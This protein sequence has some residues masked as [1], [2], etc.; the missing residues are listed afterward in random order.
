M[1]FV[2]KLKE[3]HKLARATVDDI[4]ADT[5]ELIWRAIERFKQRVT[6]SLNDAGVNPKEVPNFPEAFDDSEITHT[7]SGLKTE[8]LQIKFYRDW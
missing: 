8:H 1:R 3:K 7:F 5:E 4:L 6:T 2:L